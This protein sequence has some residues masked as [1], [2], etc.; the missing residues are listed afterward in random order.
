M[1]AKIREFTKKFIKD[2]TLLVKE[3]NTDCL[4]DQQ[5]SD[6]IKVI[7][8]LNGTV[9]YYKGS[10][11]HR[12]DGPA[13]IIPDGDKYYYRNNY[14]HREDGPALEFADGTKQYRINDKV[15]RL[16]GPAI[17][18]S[19]GNRKYF[20][21]DVE[22]TRENYLKHPSVIETIMAKYTKDI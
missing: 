22:Y 16:D 4:A 1:E 13:V 8:G 18:S 3:A 11:L 10:K 17:I 15:H 19:N 21:E 9:R 5:S 20:I 7:T 14:L 2:L 6:E 12:E